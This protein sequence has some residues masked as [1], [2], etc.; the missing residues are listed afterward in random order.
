MFQVKRL[1]GTALLPDP[2]ILSL[3]WPKLCCAKHLTC[4][5]TRSAC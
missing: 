2:S 1:L 4:G 3:G 5:S